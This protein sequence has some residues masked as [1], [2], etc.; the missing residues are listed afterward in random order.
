MVTNPE[1]GNVDDEIE[2]DLEIHSTHGETPSS[3]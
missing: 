2:I 3:F 1:V